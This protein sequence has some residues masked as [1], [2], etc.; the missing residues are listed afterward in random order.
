M[1][2]QYIPLSVQAGDPSGLFAIRLLYL[3][4]AAE[5]TYDIQCRLV[6]TLI[7]DYRGAKPLSSPQAVTH[8]EYKALSYTWGEPEFSKALY[9][10]SEDQPP[11][12]IKITE[13]LHAALQ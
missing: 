1:E 12:V 13:N 5:P 4:P 10:L 9:V 8:V 11:R 7:P 6:E 2:Y 3:L